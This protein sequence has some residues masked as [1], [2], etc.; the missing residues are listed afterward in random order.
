MCFESSKLYCSDAH[1]SRRHKIV[2]C[3][4]VKLLRIFRSSV[5]AMQL[6]DLKFDNLSLRALPIERVPEDPRKVEPQ[7]QVKGACWS[8]IKPEPLRSPVLV[9]ASSPCLALLDLQ[10]SQVCFAANK[11]S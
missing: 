10:A 3:A 7:R 5:L 6:T 8:P 9:A 1:I 2:W 11:S 4:T